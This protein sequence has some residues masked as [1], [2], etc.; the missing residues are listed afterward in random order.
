MHSSSTS[1]FRLLAC[2]IILLICTTFGSIDG[3]VAGPIFPSRNVIILPKWQPEADPDSTALFAANSFWSTVEHGMNSV[4]DQFGWT[5]QFG[6]TVE[7]VRWGEHASLFAINNMELTADTHNDIHFN[8]RGAFWEEGVMFARHT[9]SLDYELGFIHRCR[10]DVDNADSAAVFGVGEER[11]LIYNSLAQ[12]VILGTYNVVD[13]SVALRPWFKAEEYLVREDYRIPKADSNLGTSFRTLAAS[14]G[15][16]VVIDL[17]HNASS[18]IYTRAEILASFF[19]TTS[20]FFRR[21]TTI[22]TITLDDHVEIGYAFSGKA[23]KLQ[24]FVG[25]QRF[26]DDASTPIPKNNEFLSVGFRVT[27]LD[28]GF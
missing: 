8:P 6:G 26:D 23:T 25:W 24:L 5:I 3:A 10:H 12:R 2:P 21:F 16:G 17:Y 18:M 11:T 1:A 7:F 22:K 27:G 9:K 20:D 14:L 15:A 13:S 28:M 4:Q 19:G